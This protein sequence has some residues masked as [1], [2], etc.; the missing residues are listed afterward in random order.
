VTN[1][2]ISCFLTECVPL[3]WPSPWQRVSPRSTHT[4]SFGL[5]VL[6][7]W[8]VQ[9]TREA[10]MRSWVVSC[11]VTSA[12]VHGFVKQVSKTESCNQA[13]SL[14]LLGTLVFAP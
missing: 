2:P 5:L 7:P 4:L 6:G 3:Q 12:C 8:G 13:V 10:H 9:Q 11:G 14:A 1:Y